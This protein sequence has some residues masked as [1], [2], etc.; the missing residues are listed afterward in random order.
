MLKRSLDL[1]NRQSRERNVT[2]IAFG[3]KD[4]NCRRDA[5]SSHPAAYPTSQ[6]I[7]SLARFAFTRCGAKSD[8]NPLQ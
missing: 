2:L 5:V 1:L 7:V 4:A 8:F 3:Q 6:S